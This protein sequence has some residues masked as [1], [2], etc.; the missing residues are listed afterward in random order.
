M[1]LRSLFSMMAL[2]AVVAVTSAALSWRAAP[3]AYSEAKLESISGGEEGEEYG[4]KPEHPGEAAA[5]WAGLH[6]TRSTATAI[7]LNA[8]ARD[9]IEA[10]RGAGSRGSPLP[11]IRIE[12]WGPGNFGG[13]LRGILI[14][15]ND[16]DEMLV[17]SVAGGVFK[18]TDAGATWT[19]V[20]DFLPS[21]SVGS[22]LVDPDDSDTVFVGTGEGFFNA[23]AAQGLG[24]LI[25]D[26]FGDTF[27][28]LAGTDNSNFFYVNRLARIPG[29]TKLLAATRAG[30]W[31]TDDFTAVTPVWTERT[32]T[33][34]LATGDR[35]FTDLKLDT[36][37]TTPSARLYSWRFTDNANP[38][39]RRLWRSSD[40]G[41]TWTQLGA[42]EG[43]PDC[44][45]GTGC[46]RAEIGVGT[47]GVVYLSVSSTT[48][49]TRGLWR[50]PAGGGAFAQTASAVAFIERQGWYDLIMGVKPGDS[51][52]VYVGAVD[53]FKSTNAGGV[54]T[55]KTFWNPGVGQYPNDYV[56]ADL[57]V[58]AFDPTNP[59]TV[60][61]GCDGG[62]FKSTDDG[63]NFT[64][65][66]NDL[67]VAQYYGIAAHPDG[68]HVIGGTQDNG[69]HLFFGDKALWL[70]WFGGDGGFSSWDQ[71]QTQFI[72]GATPQGGLFGSGDGGS[73]ASDLTLPSTTGAAFITPF[74][75]DIN[76]GNRMIVGTNRVFY[77][78]NTRSLGAATFVD[79]SG[80][81][82]STVSAATISRHNGSVAF[83]GTATGRIFRTTTLGTP[84][85][86]TQINDVAMQ[87]FDVTWI[88]VDPHDPT[89]NTVYA[90]IADYGPDRVWKSTN[91][92]TS[93]TSIHDTLPDIPMFTV[94]VDP[95]DSDRLWLGSELG[96]WTTDGNDTSSFDWQQ[97]DYGTAW[98][99]VM[100]L[101]WATDDILW[102]GTHGRG[103]YKIH[104]SPAVVTLGEVDDS[105]GGC[106]ADGFLDP[107]EEA[108]V[109]VSVTNAGVVAL[110]NTVVSLLGVSS[111][112]IVQS[113]PQNYGSIGPGAT[114]TQDF[115][116]R[117]AGLALAQCRSL[118][119]LEATVTHDDGSGTETVT[120][121]A[122]ADPVTSTLTED[123]EDDDTAFTH[124]AAVATD[125]W[126]RVTSSAHAG[127]RSWFASD[128]NGFADKSLLSP[129]MDVGAG[130]TTIG[131]WLRYDMEGDAS[132][133]W[134][135][136]L[137]E[138]RVEGS[139]EWV[140]IGNLSSVAYDGPL[141]N[142]ST[143]PGRMAWSGT[144]LTWRNATVNLGATYNG[145]RIR[146][147]FRLV[148]DTN[149]A[150]VGFW[151]DDLTVTNVTWPDC[152]L[153][154][155][156]NLFSDGFETGDV[157]EWTTCFG[158]CPP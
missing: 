114:V 86:W 156:S 158:N 49:A 17:G 109:P 8:Q 38:A 84:T 1:K 33:T 18:S 98:T 23:D 42:G 59:N 93:W 65:L 13:R 137:L 139:D 16:T 142:N 44:A 147:R 129:W 47:D 90:T 69:S 78:A 146:F 58:V 40:D 157:D 37:T 143:A 119:E 127:L 95:L 133:R 20:D 124:E 14:N 83:V 120:L 54:I 111:G 11:N 60:F 123:A 100:Q 122:G 106:D 92:G 63:E 5:W 24:I 152:D 141:F 45:T 105:A 145:Q 4:H 144:Q 3:L 103:I 10:V 7:Q 9:Q 149:A 118:L 154:G 91:G 64:Q 81:L 97:Y 52:T 53:M 104:R 134:D 136:V 140:D 155:C 121:L 70:Q 94:V 102:T 21:L 131:F 66:N 113:G 55:K 126:A 29:T 77:S 76:N 6:E 43:L 22:M 110:S 15:P 71:Q 125:D 57:H 117:L 148:A 41:A 68:E 73:T 151:M 85:T 138:L 50:S 25:S 62:I 115:A 153:L 87:G 61:I 89:G 51:N 26:D 36:S 46:R 108:L 56:H 79:Q 130:S 96:L 34:N 135:G 80:V 74:T 67:R 27:T 28:T 75:L 48:D 31:G 12:D 128:V 101:V 19:P 150:N 30:I 99:R 132:Q 112:L 39:L 72:Y 116:V 32:G 2:F 82:G 88:E 35:G 107:G